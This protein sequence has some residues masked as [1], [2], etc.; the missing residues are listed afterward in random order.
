MSWNKDLVRR[1]PEAVLEHVPQAVA[2]PL[3]QGE[4]R[5]G[6]AVEEV[7]P[8]EVAQ[9]LGVRRQP[10]EFPGLLVLRP[11]LGAKAAFSLL[12]QR[13]GVDGHRP[14]SVGPGQSL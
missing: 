5:F 13:L 14:L 12:Q 10:Q 1:F 4:G 7:R 9:E 6:P 3:D 2:R 8:A 11:F